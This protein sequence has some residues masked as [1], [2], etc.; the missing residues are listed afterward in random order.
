MRSEL[1]AYTLVILGI[2]CGMVW[3]G[4]CGGGS[5]NAAPVQ[6]A[7]GWEKIE[8]ITMTADGTT[9]DFLNVPAGYRVLRLMGIFRGSDAAVAA[10]QFNDDIASN[11]TS[12]TIAYDGT[13][14]LL[15]SGT[16]TADS[17]D[18]GYTTVSEVVGFFTVEISNSSSQ[19]KKIRGHT[20]STTPSGESQDILSASWNNTSSE[21]TKIRVLNNGPSDFRSGS[22]FILMGLN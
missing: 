6:Q 19:V 13:V 11:Y 12:S 1:R 18:V 17:I 4:A 8:T 9:I 7:S 21:I 22:T 5:S 15:G 14:N 10:V 2:V 16:Q 3:G 20:G